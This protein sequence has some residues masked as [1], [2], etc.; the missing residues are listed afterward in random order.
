M[1]RVYPWPACRGSS[2]TFIYP[3][4][5]SLNPIPNAATP[6]PSFAAAAAI[7]ELELVVPRVDPLYR[8]LFL[9]DG[10]PGSFVWW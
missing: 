7:A 3:L 4:P 5:A 2:A 8:H 1:R 9:D 10:V 6:N